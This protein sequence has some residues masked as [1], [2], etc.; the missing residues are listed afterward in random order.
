MGKEQAIK[1]AAR[2]VGKT[3]SLKAAHLQ[4]LL[5]HAWDHQTMNATPHDNA[6]FMSKTQAAA[7]KAWIKRHNNAVDHSPLDLELSP[8]ERVT[9]NVIKELKHGNMR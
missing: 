7:Y 4:S 1:V 6:W 8:V 2:Q 9:K 5:N 3:N